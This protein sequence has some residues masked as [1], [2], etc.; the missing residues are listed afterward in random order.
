MQASA[1][2]FLYFLFFISYEYIKL[3]LGSASIEAPQDP[4]K[5]SKSARKK[6]ALLARQQ[7]RQEK[8]AK[9]TVS[10]ASD[11]PS[12]TKNSQ[13]LASPKTEEEVLSPPAELI[14]EAPEPSTGPQ[15]T[16]SPPNESISNAKPPINESVSAECEPDSELPDVSNTPNSSHKP[17]GFPSSTVDITIRQTSQSPAGNSPSK[18]TDKQDTSES[19]RQQLPEGTSQEAAEKLKKRQSF[20]TRTL[21]TLIMIGGFLRK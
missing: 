2:R 6:A 17:V 3:N 5:K 16:T 21:W 19:K 20:F 1:L 13:V 9:R 10:S 15:A 8:K 11:E 7:A 18:N 14:P 4:P 12:I